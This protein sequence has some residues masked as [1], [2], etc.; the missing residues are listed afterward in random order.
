[1]PGKTKE[2]TEKEWLEI[3]QK[4]HAQGL[5]IHCGVNRQDDFHSRACDDCI[6]NE[7]AENP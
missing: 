2:R 5:C 6:A 3:T 1:M 4:R 7:E